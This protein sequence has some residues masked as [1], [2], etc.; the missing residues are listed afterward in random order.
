MPTA[1]FYIY[2]YFFVV[3]KTVVKLVQLLNR[4]CNFAVLLDLEPLIPY[5]PTLFHEEEEKTPT[6]WP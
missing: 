1:Y 2:K 3:E 6:V 4:S 5:L